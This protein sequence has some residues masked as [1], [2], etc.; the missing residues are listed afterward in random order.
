VVGIKQAAEK[1]GISEGLLI[2]WISV[3]KIKPSVNMSTA[4]V[5]LPDERTGIELAGWD[6]FLLSDEDIEQLQKMVEDTA[7]KKSKVEA[8]HVRGQHYSVQE[9]AQLWG[10]GADKIRE[11]FENESGVIKIQSPAKKGKRA[12]KTL[13]IPESV[14]DRVQRRLS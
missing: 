3:G 14:A 6:R 7:D 1:A 5:V 9:L 8:T 11:L 12:Y 2:F 13:R 10:L 4:H